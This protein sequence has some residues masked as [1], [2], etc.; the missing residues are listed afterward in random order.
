MTTPQSIFSPCHGVVPLRPRM[1]SWMAELMQ[2]RPRLDALIDQFGAPLNIQ[3][4]DPFRRNISQLTDCVADY[5]LPFLPMFARKANKCLSYVQAARDLGIG[6][7]TASHNEVEQCLAQGVPGNRIVCTAAVKDRA[8]MALCV[9]GGVT[10]ILDNEDELELLE[11]VAI[12]P[13]KPVSVGLRLNGFERDGTKL[14]SRFGFPLTEVPALADRIS[15]SEHLR[16]DGLH[17]HLNGYS[18]ED[19]IV[20]ILQTLPL[21]RKINDDSTVP[22]FLD[23]GGGIPMNYLD[24]AA[25]W[26]AWEAE[27]DRA[28]AGDRAPIT[29][30]ND[31]LGRKSEGAGKVDSYPVAQSLVKEDWMRCILDHVADGQTVA[32]HLRDAHISLRCE[33]GRSLLDGCGITLARV[34]FCKRDSAGSPVIGVQMNRTQ[35]R[36]GFAEFALDPLMVPAAGPRKE[37]IEG[38]LAGTY[39]TESEWLTRRKMSFPEGVK[40]GDLMVFPNTAGYLMHFLESRSHQFPLAQNVFVIEGDTEYVDLDG[41]DAR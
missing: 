13:A 11:D 38:Y 24:D 29:Q 25:E 39:C 31:G 6:I 22:F 12:G 36:S 9:N 1:E 4:L 19:R 32:A 17:F 34:A 30:H 2:N 26:D 27:L 28:L 41:I 7:D 18:P 37:A 40:V 8:L 35:S 23:I 3:S 21:I 15:N 10:V 33:P 16:L 20:A 14:Y 5:D